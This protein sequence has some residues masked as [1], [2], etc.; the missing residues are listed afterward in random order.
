M[1]DFF[2]MMNSQNGK[3]IMPIVDDDGEVM[4]FDTERTAI[5][6]ADNN[7]YAKAFGYEIF[8]RGMGHVK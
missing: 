3:M 8:E 1:K 6:C 7:P 5:V 2:I 4:L